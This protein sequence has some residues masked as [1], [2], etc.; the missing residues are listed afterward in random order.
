MIPME[1]LGLQIESA[2]GAPVLLLRERSGSRILPV[3]IGP[4]EA[5]AISLGL[6]GA[7]PPRPRTHDLLL[8]TLHELGASVTK[9]EVTELSEGTFFAELELNG[10]DGTLRVSSRPSDAVAL[11]IR[12]K[13]P[14]FVAE[15]VLAEAGVVAEEDDA[16]DADEVE[17]VVEDFRAFLDE[18]DPADFGEGG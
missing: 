13:A 9:V 3:F 15:D 18:I 5:M 11:A 2:S 17:E 14:V 6:E 1:V 12:S 4:T 16:D 8:A 10:P 7:E